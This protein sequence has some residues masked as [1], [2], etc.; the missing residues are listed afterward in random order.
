MH[1]NPENFLVN[2]TKAPGSSLLSKNKHIL[3]RSR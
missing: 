3:W 1:P 2:A